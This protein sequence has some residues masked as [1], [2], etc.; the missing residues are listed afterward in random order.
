M[1]ETANITATGQWQELVAAGAGATP[2]TFFGPEAEYAT[3]TDG[4]PVSGLV[5]HIVPAKKTFVVIVGAEALWGRGWEGS[6][7]VVG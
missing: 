7:W 2:L 5:G 4:P 3:S 1:A 6:T